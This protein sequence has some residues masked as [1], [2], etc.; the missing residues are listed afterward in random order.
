VAPPAKL[1]A[2]PARSSAAAAAIM[3]L[4]RSARNESRE[5]LRE[6]AGRC[7]ATR[8]AKAARC[9]SERRPLPGGPHTMS[10][11]TCGASSART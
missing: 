4:S 10:V 5:K 6:S 2:R 11:R 3:R 9:T 1:R 8:T 7:T